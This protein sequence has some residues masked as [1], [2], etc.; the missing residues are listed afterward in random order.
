[1]KMM[2]FKAAKIILFQKIYPICLTFFH[3]LYPIWRKKF[4]FLYPIHCSKRKSYCW[5]RET[6]AILL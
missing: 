2:I 6:S 5:Q 3:F 1:M 4:H